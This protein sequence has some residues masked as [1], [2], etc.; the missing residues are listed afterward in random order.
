MA[1]KKDTVNTNEGGTTGMSL[2]AKLKTITAEI[3][4]VPKSKYN[5]NQNYYYPGETDILS[6]IKPLCDK[7]N[8]NIT[9]GID[10]DHGDPITMIGANANIVMVKLVYTIIDVETGEVMT[11]YWLG[12]G[13]D[14]QDKALYKAYT[15]GQ[16]YFLMKLFQMPTEDDP[17][18]DGVSTPKYA[19]QNNAGT[20]YK[21]SAPAG[22]KTAST[23]S[24]KT[25]PATKPATP[26]APAPAAAST[27]PT[28]AT[29]APIPA[30][31]A[32]TQ[33]APAAEVPLVC[34]GDGCT[35]PIT[36]AVSMFSQDQYGRPLCLK[37]QKNY[38]KI[39]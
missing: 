3:G 26:P 28:P 13:Q 21:S 34:S 38:P 18:E 16:K 29:T 15:G 20:G 7:Y 33:A 30:P 22:N 10:Y 1:N 8:V 27:P 11:R 4:E 12:T 39:K 17:E 37:C 25:A 19:Q 35:N 9:V 2:A 36:K 32:A 14:N 5:K 6:V 24:P 31:P 23:A